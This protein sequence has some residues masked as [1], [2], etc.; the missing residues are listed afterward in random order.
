LSYIAFF[1]LIHDFFSKGTALICIHGPNYI[2]ICKG[3]I[4]RSLAEDP[5][6]KDKWV[7]YDMIVF[8]CPT[9]P[10]DQVKE[11]P[12]SLFGQGAE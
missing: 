2:Q 4:N 11:N 9:M 1:Q 3:G 8:S 6:S 10:D 12:V 7:S 5:V